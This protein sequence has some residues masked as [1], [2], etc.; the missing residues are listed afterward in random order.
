MGMLEL[1]FP[2][3]MTLNWPCKVNKLS[4]G[5][6]SSLTTDFSLNIQCFPTPFQPYSG[7]SLW[8]V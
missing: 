5:S 8:P 1:V 6:T 2:S 4:R 7:V 3:C